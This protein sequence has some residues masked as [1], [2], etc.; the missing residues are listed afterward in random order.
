MSVFATKKL[1]SKGDLFAALD[2]GTC[3]VTCAIA[4]PDVRETTS[5]RLLGLGQQS[6]R[7]LK[8]GMITD[9]DALE[10]SILNAVH[11]AEQNAER[12][13]GSL[14]VSLPAN[15]IQSHIFQVEI[16]LSGEAVNLQHIRQ[17]LTLGKHAQEYR[18]SQ[19]IHALPIGYAIDDQQGVKDPKGMFGERL[20]AQ[21]HVL[22]APTTL[23]KN[24]ASCIGRCHLDVSGFVVSSYASGLATLV[25]D[26]LELGVTVIDIGGGSTTIASFVEGALVYLGSI[27]VGGTHITNDLA[28]GLSTP[29]SQAE[30]LKTLYGS[31]FPI[32]LDDKEQ[33]LVPQLGEEHAAPHQ[34]PKSFFTGIIRA[35]VEEIFELT[36]QKIQSSGMGDLIQ[37]R[38]VITGGASQLP[39]LVEF[40]SQTWNKPVRLGQPLGISGEELSKNPSFSTIAGLLHYA[41][42]DERSREMQLPPQD[43]HFW[44]R[45]LSW[46]RAG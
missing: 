14:Y 35:R 8:S 24:I 32:S 40:V 26:E 6:A 4:T 5:M 7:G 43:G 30:R 29:V 12:T 1:S 23:L 33:I 3:K 46:F 45:V 17:L 19:I 9:M 27:P 38:I 25:D 31:V 13:I 11:T 44:Q 39:G 41:S 2:I 10:D 15:V 28:R 42:R 18:Q 16:P 20:R 22:S 21:I 36:Q 37:Q 34:V